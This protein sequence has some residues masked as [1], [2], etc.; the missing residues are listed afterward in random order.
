[1][2]ALFGMR[3]KQFL[4][5][6][7][8]LCM[9]AAASPAY[10]AETAVQKTQQA[11]TAE[12]KASVASI[13]NGTYHIHSSLNT[14]QV[15]D[16]VGAGTS[17]GTRMQLYKKKLELQGSENQKFDIT[18][19][20]SGWYIIKEI[21]SGKVVDVKGGS[22]NSGTPVQ[23]YT[24]NNT[25]AQHWKFYS[26][27]NGYYY[28]K[29]ELGNYLDATGGASKNGTPLQVYRYN[30]TTAQKWKL[31][32]GLKKSSAAKVSNGTFQI[33]SGLN[34]SQVIDITGAG[35]ANGTKVQLY[36]NYGNENQKFDIKLVSGGWYEIYDV[37]SGKVLDV[38]GGAA[39]N[40]VPVQ[41][42]DRNGTA[43]QHWKFF[44]AGSGFYYIQ[45][46]LG[47]FLDAKS[48][49]SANG[50]QVQVY[51][52]NATKAQK[53]K[54]TGT[55]KRK[56]SAT[57][58]TGNT[59]TKGV[60]SQ[61]AVS[62]LQADTSLGL[63]GN[64][65]TSITVMARTLLDAGYEPTFVAGVLANIIKEGSV[66][67]FE[68]S[69][70]KSGEPAYLVYMDKNYSYRS[71]YSGKNVTSVSL[72]ALYQ[73][74]VNLQKGG[75]KGKFGL[76]CAQWTGGRTK[77]LVEIYKNEA[78]GSDRIT[79]SQASKAECRM[80]IKELSGNKKWVYTGW[81]SASAKMTAANAAYEA[82]SRFC[83]NYEVPAN[84]TVKARERG[85]L[86]KKVYQV[87]MK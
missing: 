51:Q 5:G 39:G 83:L 71:K 53:W 25:A 3:T 70:Y 41:L 13:A 74:L 68:S 1:M 57:G 87:I 58:T 60:S 81:K 50:T 29:N 78:G 7:L 86:A 17:N 23:L 52:F 49:K 30:G 9:L 34:T 73:M 43:A 80:I 4:A 37:N 16:A 48:G 69:A 85:N 38:K 63:K 15:V 82:G 8:A 79:F 76:G 18:R 62:N 36:K 28:I 56:T 46:E 55:T 40:S 44:S 84:R 31:S 33:C 61:R 67:Q 10:A 42:Y 35:K 21:N 75:W 24:Y 54:L 19:L 22:K 26:A 72:S 66:G 20:S 59:A 14:A 65:K 47:Y 27:G 12:L 64:K 2:K 11:A 45:N 77:T 6:V 32:A